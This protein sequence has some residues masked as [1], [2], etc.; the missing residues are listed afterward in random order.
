M[1]SK[2]HSKQIIRLLDGFSLGK[3]VSET[4]LMEFCAVASKFE[5]GVV[6]NTV[7][8]FLDGSLDRDHRFPP[9]VP[10][11]ANI[12]REKKGKGTFYPGVGYLE[13]VN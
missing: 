7:T 9:T 5:I 8:K 4:A 10:E 12:L 1:S 13:C 2:E 6:E 11:F 3:A